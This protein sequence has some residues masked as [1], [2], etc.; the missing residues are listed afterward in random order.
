MLAKVDCST[1]S[2]TDSKMRAAGAPLEPAWVSENR[3]SLAEMAT[4]EAWAL[5]MVRCIA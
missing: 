3:A 2:V 4:T 5:A 1:A